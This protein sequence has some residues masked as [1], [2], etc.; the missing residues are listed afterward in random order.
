MYLN[1]WQKFTKIIWTNTYKRQFQKIYF[2]ETDTAFIYGDPLALAA[3]K[4]RISYL[5]RITNWC[6]PKLKKEDSFRTLLFILQNY[7][8]LDSGSKNSATAFDQKRERR[9]LFTEGC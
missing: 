2:C 1:Q 9:E 5:R 3:L 6:S 7:P 8:V 4:T